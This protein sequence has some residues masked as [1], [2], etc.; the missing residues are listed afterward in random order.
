MAER[1]ASAHG[2]FGPA[3]ARGEP[4]RVDAFVRLHRHHE[5]GATVVGR[6]KLADHGPGVGNSRGPQ[7]G[8]ELPVAL[9]DH[10]REIRRR[11]FPRRFVRGVDGVAVGVR[12]LDS[13]G[14]RGHG[15]LLRWLSYAHKPGGECYAKA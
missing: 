12:G 1:S 5:R 7:A 14:L 15:P 4:A 3:P 11:G 13:N 10:W 6:D 2:A 9:R 8:T